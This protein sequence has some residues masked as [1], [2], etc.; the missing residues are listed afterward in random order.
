[1]G[2]FDDLVAKKPPEREDVR[3]DG[4]RIPTQEQFNEVARNASPMSNFAAGMGGGLRAPYLG[5]RQVVGA[6]NQD[7]VAEHFRTMD[8]LR[9]TKAGMFG[10]M[11]GQAAPMVASAMVPWTN[12]VL[13]SGAVGA[14]FGF[15]Q[16]TRPEEKGADARIKNTTEGAL[17]GAAFPAV[18]AAAK[19]TGALVRPFFGKGQERIAGDVLNRMASNADDAIAKA[20]NATELVP[21]SKPTLSQATMDPGLASME[22]TMFAIDPTKSRAALLN[23]TGEQTAAQ[24]D[25]IRSWAKGAPAISAAERSR[26]AA[27]EAAYGKAY[28]AGFDPAKVADPRVQQQLQSLLKKPAV[29]KAIN[30][31]KELAANEGID[32]ADPAGSLQGLHYVKKAL[33]DAIQRADGDNVKR[34]LTGVQKNLLDSMDELSPDYA[35]ARKAFA[36]ASKPIDQMAVGQRLVDKSTNALMQNTGNEK[37]YA[38]KFGQLVADEDSLVRQA[39]G[40]RANRGLADVLEP[41]QL[42]SINNVLADLQRMQQAKDIGRPMGSPTAQYLVGKNIVRSM[43]GPIGLPESMAD[44]VLADT[45]VS[46]PASF[47]LKSPEERVLGLLGDALTDP[48]TAARLMEQARKMPPGPARELLERQA[49][50]LLRGATAAGG[51]GLLQPP[52]Q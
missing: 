5:G 35:A 1:M 23:R 48:G 52:Q 37:L 49:L 8:S 47:L 22:Q 11:V 15:M 28:A 34:V 50:G 12:T 43:A 10:E 39:T 44:K 31:A 13:G 25:S 6:S 2:A 40:F 16:P 41:D 14:G 33:D 21:G 46:R 26:A 42:G 27:A 18:V 30:E 17:F 19:A 45:L 51:A 36:D 24:L 38:N 29:Q 9:Q 3:K 20:R 32:I 7:D 4:R